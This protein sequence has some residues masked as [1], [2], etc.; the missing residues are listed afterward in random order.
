MRIKEQTVGKLRVR[1]FENRRDLGAYAASEAAAALRQ[2][3]QQ[4]QE[5]NLIFAAAPSQSEF[6][7]AL[8]QEP[9]IDW[10]SVNAFH[11]DEYVGLSI[12][13]AGSFTNFLNQAAFDRLPF[14][15]VYRL[16]GAA[17][18]KEEC[19]RYAALLREHPIDAVFMGVGENGHIAFN[20]PPVADF[21]DSTAIKVV[22]LDDTCRMQQVHDKCFPTFDDVPKQAF[23]LTVPTLLSAGR[24]FC[25]VPAATKASAVAR[26]LTGPINESCPASILRTHDNATLYLDPDSA[27]EYL[28]GI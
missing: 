17:D 15:N 22:T 7:E 4:K 10:T 9:D 19:A 3:L 28:R 20:D 23:T 14:K 1:I 12:G 25:M 6:L 2:L 18:P 8:C 26:M 21:H 27:A 13:Q 16:N 24:L 11:M 5:V